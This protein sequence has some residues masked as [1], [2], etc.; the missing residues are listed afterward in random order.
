M[1]A[2]EGSVSQDTATQS[3][4]IQ[5]GTKGSGRTI[6]PS[7]PYVE[8]PG[9]GK[10]QYKIAACIAS[11]KANRPRRRRSNLGSKEQRAYLTKASKRSEGSNR[12]S[13]E[14]PEKMHKPDSGKP[15]KGYGSVCIYRSPS[16]NFQG[17]CSK[18][19]HLLHLNRDMGMSAIT[20]GDFDVDM[21]PVCI[22][23]SPSSN[24]QGI[25]S[26]LDHLLHLNRDMGMSTIIAGDFDV[27][28]LL[29]I[30]NSYGADIVFRES[31]R[32]CRTTQTCPGNIILN[33]SKFWPSDI[34]RTTKAGRCPGMPIEVNNYRPVSLLTG[35]S[36][37][38]EVQ[39]KSAVTVNTGF[40]DHKGQ[41]IS[42]E[43]QRQ[44]AVQECP[45][46]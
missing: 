22:Y 31:T 20:S 41:V 33:N 29:N 12:S 27:D 14:P 11:G 10:G 1:M 8:G 2:E 34:A 28:M 40:S 26:K 7:Y 13:S 45:S 18:L 42:I 15:V 19:D 3:E 17:I 5:E 16:S 30:L 4:I 21:L 32:I 25:C 24:F 23:R 46:R 6:N 9:N 38:F 39:C 35:F 36:K 43:Q 44:G 37:L